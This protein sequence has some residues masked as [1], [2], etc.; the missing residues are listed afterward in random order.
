MSQENCCFN[1][2]FYPV[3]ITVGD[4]GDPGSD[5]ICA[6]QIVD[7]GWHE[8]NTILSGNYISL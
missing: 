8:C 1:D 4:L 6:D 3:K 7:S 2:A 5:P